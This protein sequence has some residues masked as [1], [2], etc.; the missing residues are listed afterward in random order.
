[1]RSRAIFS[2]QAGEKREDGPVIPA[3]IS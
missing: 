2:G 3:V 1:V